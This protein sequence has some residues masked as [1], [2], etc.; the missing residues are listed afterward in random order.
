MG[1]ELELIENVKC[2]LAKNM[3]L[4]QI[5]LIIGG[6]TT[7]NGEIV[8]KLHGDLLGSITTGD[9][10]TGLSDNTLKIRP[11]EVGEKIVITEN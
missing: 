8:I 9:V 4:G 10:W 3:G 2:V 5:G 11:L 7:H 1:V 6:N